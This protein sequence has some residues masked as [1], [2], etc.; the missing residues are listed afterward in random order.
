M[1]RRSIGVR[2]SLLDYSSVVK[3]ILAQS[4]QTV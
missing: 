3:A 4:V 1:A 2:F